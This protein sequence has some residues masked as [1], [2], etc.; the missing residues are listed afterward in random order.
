MSRLV[1]GEEY[2]SKYV[3]IRAFNTCLTHCLDEHE[4]ATE[5]LVFQRIEFIDTISLC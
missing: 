4:L 2:T 3:R 1:M 5:K